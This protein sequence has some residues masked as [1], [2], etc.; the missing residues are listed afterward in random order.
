[1]ESFQNFR[2]L[3]GRITRDLNPGKYRMKVYNRNIIIDLDYNV[4]SYHGKKHIVLSTTSKLGTGRFFGYALVFG[5]GYCL[6]AI[7]VIYFFS[8]K[9]RNKQYD[10]ASMKWE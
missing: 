4:T 8:I 10:I 5:S 6:I 3:W 2:K 9:N 7:L 1:M